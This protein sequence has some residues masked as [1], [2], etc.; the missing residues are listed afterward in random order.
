MYWINTYLKPPNI[1]IYDIGKN[2]INKK[3]KQYTTILKTVTKSVPVKAH[4]LIEMVKHYYSPLH[5]IYYIIIAKLPNINKDIAL[6]M[7]F[8]AINNSIGF[9][10][11]IPILLVF[12]AYLYIVESNIPNFIVITQA[13]AFKKAIKKIKKFKIKR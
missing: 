5:Y 4:N 8:K 13:A 10:G 6:Q 12:G 1:I 2:F 3:F 9:N 7:A 11:F